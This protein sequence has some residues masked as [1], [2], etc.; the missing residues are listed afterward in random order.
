MLKSMVLKS[1][2]RG[3]PGKRTVLAAMIIHGTKFLARQFSH[4]LNPFS[5]VYLKAHTTE[6]WGLSMRKYLSCLDFFSMDDQGPARYYCCSVLV[7]CAQ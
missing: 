5:V 1:L 4:G 3:M 2:Q 7:V 6:K